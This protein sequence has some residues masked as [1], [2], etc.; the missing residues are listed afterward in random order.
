MTSLPP[1]IFSAPRRA[2]AR[3]RMRRLQQQEGAARYIADDMAEDVLERLAFL[4]HEPARALVEGDIT[5]AISSALAARGC[6]VVRADPQPAPREIGGEIA[7]DEALPRPFPGAFDL[8]VNVGTL[9]T[10]NDL[11]GALVHLRAMLAPGGLA[12]ISMIGAGSLPKL[13]A[14]MF[15]ADGDQPAARIHPQVDVRAGGQLLQRT[16]FADP[17]VDS[18]TLD[19]RFGSLERLVGDLREQGLGNCLASP[20]PPLGKAGYRRAAQAF[21]EAADADGRVTERFEIL[22]LSGWA[23]AIRPP[24][25]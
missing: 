23:R 15:A 1:T 25:F 13:R 12:M 8:C 6:A 16:G 7:I 9:A 4:R 21:A 22:T 20:A 5:G 2:Q 14:I 17:V 19:V 10:V 24:K 18:R 11:P 3:R